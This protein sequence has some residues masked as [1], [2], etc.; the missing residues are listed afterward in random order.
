MLATLLCSL[1]L[2]ANPDITFDSILVLPPSGPGIRSPFR[3]DPVLAQIARAEFHP[4]GAGEQ[5]GNKT[6]ERLTPNQDGTFAAPA[7]AGGYAFAS[8]T[9]A[10]DSIM[11]L[12][13]GGHALVYFNGEP[14]MGDP[15]DNN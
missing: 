2:G 5:I 15:Y 4:P 1:V 9:G 8:F 10:E 13:A 6:W 12:E 7:L 14:R 11:I 3:P